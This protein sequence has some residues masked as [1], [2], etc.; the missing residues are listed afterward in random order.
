VGVEPRGAEVRVSIADNGTGIPESDRTHL[1]TP[2]FTTK[3]QG[4][5]VGLGLF[6][7][8]SIARAH[9]GRIEV[10]STPGKGSTFTVC[11]PA[12]TRGD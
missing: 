8:E 6:I 1:F 11:L 7:S 4:K 5:G 12:G 3:D 9:D 2:F 10:E